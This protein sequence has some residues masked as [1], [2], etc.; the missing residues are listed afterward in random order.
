MQRAADDFDA[1]SRRLGELKSESSR[2]R[3]SLAPQIGPQ[4]L[5]AESGAD[6]VIYGGAAGGGKSYGLLLEALRHT[7]YVRGFYAVFFRRQMTE[8][9]NPGGLWDES[10]NIF[11]MVGGTPIMGLHEWRWPNLSKVRFAHLQMESDVL[12]WHG[13]QVPFLAFDELTQFTFHQFWYLISR[14]RS[15][16]G[17]RPYIR[18]TCNPDAE[19]WVANFISWWIDQDT[20]FAI[21]DRAGVMRYVVRGPDDNLLWGDTADEVRPYLTI[22]KDWPDDIEK[23]EPKSVTFIPAKLSD[24][25]ALLAKDP[26]YLASLLAQP[27]VDRERLL[28]GNWKIRPAAGLYFRRGWCEVI[29]VAP[30][31][32]KQVRYWDLASTEKTEKNDPD[33]TVGVKLGRDDD[34]M[35]YVLDV[36]RER[37][38]PFEVERLVKNTAS[39]DKRNTVIGF[40]LD[41]GQAGKSQAAY[42]VRSLTG[43]TVRPA[44]ETGDKITRF[45]PF[46]SQCKAGNVKIVSG[47]WNDAFFR[48]LEGFPELAHDDD[49]DS[50]AGALELLGFQPSWVITDEMLNRARIPVRRYG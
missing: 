26:N 34:G 9:T 47:S 24:N 16:C 14:N 11:S 12:S 36:V 32:L 27:L 3:Q 13:A 28:G 25:P 38:G 41:P 35:I 50:C 5:F 39:T 1:I 8:I 46:S 10:L 45:G 42:L 44:S 15:T 37:C 7:P 19:S 2:P 20:G 21:N 23:P 31:R 40:G 22:P 6:I 43:Y 4:T 30:A 29:D 33:W 48:T 49:V 17:V 18:A